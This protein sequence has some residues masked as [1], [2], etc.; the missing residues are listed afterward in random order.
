MT[1]PAEAH[2]TEAEAIARKGILRAPGKVCCEGERCLSCD[3]VCQ[4]CVDVCPNRAN[5]AVRLPDG[6]TEIVHVD[7]MCNELRQLHGLLLRTPPSRAEG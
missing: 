6:R 5:V 2:P 4:N 3:T 1:S 7:K